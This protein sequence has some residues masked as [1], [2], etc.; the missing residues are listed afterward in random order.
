[1]SPKRDLKIPV[2]GRAAAAAVSHGFFEKMGGLLSVLVQFT[3]V[4]I[5]VRY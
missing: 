4:E 3:I 1:M 2:H 5:I